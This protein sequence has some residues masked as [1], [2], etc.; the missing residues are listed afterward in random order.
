MIAY[1]PIDISCKIPEHELLVDY[2]EKNHITN[3]KDQ[4]GYTSLLCAIASKNLI[5]NWQD[6]N[7]VFSNRTNK[8]LTFA[9]GVTDIFPELIDI[10]N[11]LPFKDILG[12]VLNLH[13]TLLESHRDDLLN[14]GV[15]S[16]ERYNVLLSPHYEQDS[17]F[18]SKEKHGEKHY[19]KILKE[20]P[21]Y[22][23]NNNEAY[24]GADIVL[25][26]RVILIL[27]GNLDEQKHIE[28]INRSVEKFKD[29]VIRY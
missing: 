19:P 12:L 26:K 8:E 10:A 14:L 21:I 22:A 5:L 3:L 24:H 6:A 7:D 25:D 17:F 29:Y 1:T 13:T 23:F 28:L 9:P 2:I 16:P 27:I 11:L 18:I 4:Y 15:Y 20:Y